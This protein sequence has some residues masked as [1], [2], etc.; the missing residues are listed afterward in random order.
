MYYHI[1]RSTA[2]P[3][4]FSFLFSILTFLSFLLTEYSPFSS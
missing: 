4:P 2:F 1:S 3:F